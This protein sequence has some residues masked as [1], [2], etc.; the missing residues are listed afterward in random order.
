[1][2]IIVKN[3]FPYAILL[4]NAANYED[5]FAPEQVLAEFDAL[6]YKTYDISRKQITEIIL[7]KSGSIALATKSSIIIRT[8]CQSDEII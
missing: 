5:P 8:E 1:M 2:N 4:S 3:N 7:S 6:Q